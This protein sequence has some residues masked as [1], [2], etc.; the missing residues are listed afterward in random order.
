MTIS[1]VGLILFF[2]VF[3]EPQ[4]LLLPFALILAILDTIF[5][6]KP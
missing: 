1:I 5:A 4:I 6:P 2:V 3:V